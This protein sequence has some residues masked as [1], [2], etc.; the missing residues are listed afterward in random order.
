MI[1]MKKEITAEVFLVGGENTHPHDAAEYLISSAGESALVDSGTGKCNERIIN[2]IKKSGINP[3]TI[4]YIFLTHCH[5][6]HTGGAAALK[7]LTGAE[8]IAHELDSIYLEEGNSEV[9]AASWYGEQQPL[10]YIDRKINADRTLFR[11]GKLEIM[12][13]HTPGHTPGSIVLLIDSCGK[14]VLFGQDVHG[15]LHPA[16]KSDRAAYIRS[17]NI[18]L[19]LEAD[20][21]CEGHYGVVSGKDKVRNFI[22]SFIS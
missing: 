17:L 8:I 7:E 3:D 10:F 16:L 14:K 11:L 22:R 19:T 5:Y 18:L 1:I 9:T 6:D 13:I 12:A 15:P 20:I 21:L 4:K 2:N